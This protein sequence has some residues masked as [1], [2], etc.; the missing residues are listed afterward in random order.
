MYLIAG[1]A[2]FVGLNATKILAERGQQ[3]VITTRRRADAQADEVV[4][5]ANG[6]VALEVVDLNNLHEVDDLFSRYDFAGVLH[7]ATNH[8]FAPNRAT[9]W[10]SYNVLFNTL[11]AATAWGVPRFVLAS[12]TVVYRG[13]PG[14]WREDLPL[15]T[16]LAA[17]GGPGA[18]LFEVTLKRVMELLALDY[19]TP[20]TPQDLAPALGRTRASTQMETAVVRFPSQCGPYYTSMFNAVACL[21]HVLAGRLDAMPAGRRLRPWN[22]LSY[23]LDSASALVEV[24]LA[25]TLPSRVYNVASGL[26]VSAR[27]IAQAAAR[28]AP[29]AAERLQLEATSLEGQPQNSYMDLTRIERDLGWKP[30]FGDLDRMLGHYVEWLREHRF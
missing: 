29:K 14:P 16:D 28:V 13:T 25:P 12:S 9:N 17:V 24:L 6:A 4:A 27:E 8:M 19:G 30:R 26:R 3:V 5:S 23:A 21:A 20:M 22:D 10:T 11:Q 15:P 7:T 1:G 18:P 2:G